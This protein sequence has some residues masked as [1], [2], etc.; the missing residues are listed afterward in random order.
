MRVCR[1]A[2]RIASMMRLQNH[3]VQAVSARTLAR[4]VFHYL[5]H[6][7]SHQCGGRWSSRDAEQWMVA[8]FGCEWLSTGVRHL[9]RRG[10]ARRFVS[11]ATPAITPLITSSLVTKEK[12]NGVVQ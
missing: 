3:S 11:P 5:C 8:R 10:G 2:R 4:K 6:P 12:K 1:L 7:F 9:L